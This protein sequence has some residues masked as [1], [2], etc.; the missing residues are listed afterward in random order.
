MNQLRDDDDPTLQPLQFPDSK[1][2]FHAHIAYSSS[3]QTCEIQRKGVGHVIISQTADEL[4]LRRTL[5][6]I[7]KI[8]PA[9]STT[10]PHLSLVPFAFLW[11]GSVEHEGSTSG[12]V[13]KERRRGPEIKRALHCETTSSDL[14]PHLQSVETPSSSQ[15]IK[16]KQARTLNLHSLPVQAELYPHILVLNIRDH[17]SPHILQGSSV[18]L[19]SNQM[20]LLRS[21]RQMGTIELEGADR[22]NRKSTLDR[23][24]DSK[25]KST[26]NA[27]LWHITMRRSNSRKSA[28]KNSPLR[29]L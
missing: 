22:N 12:I 19:Q 13:K 7:T 28:D 6:S 1:Q 16:Y 11:V 17:P 21:R 2:V 25:C 3:N 23:I 8:Q 14:P 24:R 20:T 9:G 10:V 26:R 4:F 15:N 29:H 5:Q 18:C 27:M